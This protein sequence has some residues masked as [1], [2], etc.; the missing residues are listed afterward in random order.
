MYAA[1]ESTLLMHPN[2][3]VNVNNECLAFHGICHFYAPQ[4]ME[5]YFCPC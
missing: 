1:A 3:A 2:Q 5:I 4:I